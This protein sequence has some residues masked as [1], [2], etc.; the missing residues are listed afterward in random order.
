MKKKR[1]DGTEPAYLKK[2]FTELVEGVSELADIRREYASASPQDRLRAAEWNYDAAMADWL[3]SHALVQAGQEGLDRPQWPSGYAALAVDPAYA[4]ALLTVGSIEYQLE[5]VDE[6]MKLF[7]RLLEL[8]R[9]TEDLIVIIDK[10]GDFLIS[11][12]DFIHAHAFYAAACDSFPDVPVF[13]AGRGY[14]CGK[15]DRP[16]EAIAA[17]RR[18]VELDPRSHLW[19]NDLG[20]SLMEARQYSEALPILEQ[21]VALSPPDYELARNNLA[22]LRKILT[23]Q[24]RRAQAP[25]SA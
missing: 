18:A 4:P 17:H 9:Q 15:L 6:A 20:Y 14:C 23:R 21:A 5:R 16:E 1:S 11:E 24:Q 12:E 3:F 7:R 13:H 25:R 19:L 22:E 8:P 10:A 2:S